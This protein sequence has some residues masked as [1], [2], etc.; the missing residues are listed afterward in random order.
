MP[1]DCDLKECGRIGEQEMFP[2]QIPSAQ[3]ARHGDIRCRICPEIEDEFPANPAIF[4]SS[5]CL[6]NER[7]ASLQCAPGYRRASR[8][9]VEQLRVLRASRAA[10]PAAG[11]L[12]EKSGQAPRRPKMENGLRGAR[13]QER[14]I[15]TVR[16]ASHSCQWRHS[17]GGRKTSP[18]RVALYSRYGWLFRYLRQKSRAARTSLSCHSH[19]GSRDQSTRAS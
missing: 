13:P 16:A 2:A 5:R 9:Y 11:T 3:V 6:E 4:S 14:G 19:A 7:R 17:R 18:D 12:A 15:A 8:I 1:V 10:G